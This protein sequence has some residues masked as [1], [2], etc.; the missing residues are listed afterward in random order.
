MHLQFS[1]CF[2]IETKKVEQL[3]HICS[4]TEIRVKHDQSKKQVGS[5]GIWT[6][7]LSHP[8]RESYP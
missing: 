6:R 4:N 1:N 2:P 3:E 8:K 5:S 7:D